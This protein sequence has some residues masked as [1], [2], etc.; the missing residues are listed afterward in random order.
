MALGQEY[1][2][3][4]G[5]IRDQVVRSLKDW[6]SLIARAVTGRHRGRRPF[7]RARRAAIRLRDGWHRHVVSAVFQAAGP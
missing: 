1:R 6:H 4:P 7:P 3:R 2:D 5:T